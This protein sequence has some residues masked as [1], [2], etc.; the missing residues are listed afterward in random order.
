MTTPSVESQGEAL[1]KISLALE[2]IVG[3]GVRGGDTCWGYCGSPGIAKRALLLVAGA[4]AE[5]NKKK[6]C[7][8]C[9]EYDYDCC[10]PT[11]FLGKP[12]ANV[13]TVPAPVTEVPPYDFAP[14]VPPFRYDEMGSMIMDAANHLIVDV[15][16]WG[17]LTGGTLK[18]HIEEAKAIQDRLGEHI[19][20]LLNASS[21][22]AGV[23]SPAEEKDL[24]EKET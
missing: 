12:D 19:T 7:H 18:L 10:C 15:R 14:W 1:Q 20:K 9:G 21:V 17:F 11:E 16:G 4:D 23:S 13:N 24:E 22:G 3:K 6:I 8:R 2:T 5:Q